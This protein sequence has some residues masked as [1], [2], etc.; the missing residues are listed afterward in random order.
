MLEAFFA[1]CRCTLQSA[2]S[3]QKVLTGIDKMLGSV[4]RQRICYTNPALA[5][6]YLGVVC[7]CY[8]A[9]G[10]SRK[11]KKFAKMLL[12]LGLEQNW[13]EKQAEALAWLFVVFFR[14]GNW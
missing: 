4:Q 7:H 6:E 11:A 8:G 10:E 12:H 14:L 5:A 2:D 1:K 9:S 13:P 3:H